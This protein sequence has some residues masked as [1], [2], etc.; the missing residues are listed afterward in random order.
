MTNS[1]IQFE[2]APSYINKFLQ[3]RVTKGGCVVPARNLSTGEV[4]S[5]YIVHKPSLKK[6]VLDRCK[7]AISCCLKDS[8][9]SPFE[10]GNSNN[11]VKTTFEKGILTVEKVANSTGP[12]CPFIPFTPEWREWREEQFAL[13]RERGFI[14]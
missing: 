6:E 14:N 7:W 5:L 10:D 1:T 12:Q 4:G 9:K 11:F 2:I 13:L 8:S 3:G